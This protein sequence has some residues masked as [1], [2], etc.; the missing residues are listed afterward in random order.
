MR[1]VGIG[2]LFIPHHH[3]AAGFAP[4][5]AR[6]VEVRTFDWRLSGFQELQ[7]INLAVEKG[8]AGAFTPPP[9]IFDAVAHADIL[10]VQFCPVPAALLA[11]APPFSTARLISCSSSN[12]ESCQSKVRTSTPRAATGA[13]PAAMWRWGMNGSPMPTSLMVVPFQRLSMPPVAS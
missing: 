2:D 13:K 10:V 4:V 11:A 12:P 7:E 8:G 3:I 1:L 6:G 9:A 5:A